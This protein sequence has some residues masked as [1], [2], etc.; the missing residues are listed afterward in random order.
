[1][2]IRRGKGRGKLL[3]PLPILGFGKKEKIT[4]T[5]LQKICK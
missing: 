5:K 4:N 2:G 3:L 1:M